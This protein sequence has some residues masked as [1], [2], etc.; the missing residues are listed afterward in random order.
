MNRI[1]ASKKDIIV[2]DEE[3]TKSFVCEIC[4]DKFS[5]EELLLEHLMNKKIDY[6]LNEDSDNE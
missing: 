3:D 2:I 4:N 6:E 5:T 1:K